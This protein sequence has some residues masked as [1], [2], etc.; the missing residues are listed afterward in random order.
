MPSDLE[1]ILDT[2]TPLQDIVDVAL[3][4]QRNAS[5]LVALVSEQLELNPELLLGLN[6]GLVN[7]DL[8]RL[9]EVM[10]EALEGRRTASVAQTPSELTDFLWRQSNL[11][12]LDTLFLRYHS[13][14]YH[15]A[16]RTGAQETEVEREDLESQTPC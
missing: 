1:E 11:D 5:V 10:L 14:R 15:E 12:T 3:A 6:R 9:L 2:G 7:E 4:Y 13:W 8:L 16:L